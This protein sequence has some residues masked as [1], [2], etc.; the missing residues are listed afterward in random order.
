M[1]NELDWKFSNLKNQYDTWIRIIRSIDPPLARCWQWLPFWFILNFCQ[2]LVNSMIFT[3][4][5][6]FI[7]TLLLICQCKYQIALQFWK[8]LLKSFYSRW[9]GLIRSKIEEVM[10]DWNLAY[11]VTDWQGPQYYTDSY[12][13]TATVPTKHCN[14]QWVLL[15]YIRCPL[16]IYSAL[17]PVCTELQ[18]NHLLSFVYFWLLNKILN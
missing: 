13:G 16:Q 3:E 15:C 18:T 7:L 1:K 8:E 10:A 2:F 17:T 9:C 5:W 12:T 4:S 6:K 14:S 11:T